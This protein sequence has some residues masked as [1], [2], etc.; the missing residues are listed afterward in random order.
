L[1]GF[2]ILI[3]FTKNKKNRM[4]KF[5]LIGTILLMSVTMVKSQVLLSLIFGDK[6]NSEGVEFGMNGGFNLS[7]IR[8]I[9]ESK[10]MNNWELGFYFDI[11]AK[12]KTPWYIVTGVYV[13]SN[14]GGRNIPLDYPGNPVINDSVYNGFVNAKGS[15][16][17]KFNTF[18]VPMNLRYLSK[19]GIFIEGGAQVGLVFKTHDIYTAEIDDNTLKYAEDRKVKDNGLYKWFDGGVNGGIGYKFKKGL[20]TKIGVWYYVGLTNIYKNDL[21]PKAY[22]SS[23]YVL[24]TI[25]IGKKKA[26]KARA[27]KE[28][29]EQK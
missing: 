15:V 17:K 20:G 22:N 4:K 1:K 25:P 23:L 10:G 11:L 16:T 13:K 5:I 29:A 18:Y 24:A 2:E 19:S 7:Y 6:L 9:A 14:V 21:G 3:T 8:G 28:A 27:E 12:K 26:E